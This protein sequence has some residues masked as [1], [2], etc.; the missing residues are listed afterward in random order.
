MATK[1]DELQ[2]RRMRLQRAIDSGVRRVR[3]EEGSQEYRSLDEM[4]QVR[5]DLDRRI[6][7]IQGT[8]R[9]RGPI[10]LTATKGVS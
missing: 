7:E 2:D 10:K 3:Y 5:D 6:A 4:L 9:R 1:L 8:R